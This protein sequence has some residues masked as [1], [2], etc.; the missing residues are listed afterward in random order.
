MAPYDE[1]WKSSVREERVR[2]S[3]GGRIVIPMPFREAM[4]VKTGDELVLRLEG[5]CLMVY[6]PGEAVRQAQAIVRRYV[7]SDRSLSAELIRDR[8]REQE[9]G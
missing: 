3:D 9:N 7:A 8:K 2:M 6:S 4:G 1:A 5:N